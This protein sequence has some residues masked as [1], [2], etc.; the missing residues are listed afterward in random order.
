M[1]YIFLIFPL[2][3]LTTH[4]YAQEAK[5]SEASVIPAYPKNE[6]GLVGETNFGN[7]EFGGPSMAQYKR[8]VKENMAYR[9]NAGVGTYD[10]FSLDSYFGIIGDTILEKQTW[11][12]ATMAFAGAGVEMHR[13]FYKHIYLYAAVD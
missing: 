12:R 4:I 7:E 1:K 2:V 11:Q 13:H 3:L 6:I 9:I 5:P 8:W 10:N